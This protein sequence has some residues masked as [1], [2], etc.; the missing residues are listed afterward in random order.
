MAQL[1]RMPATQGRPVPRPPAGFS[2]LPA[3]MLPHW[4][5]LAEQNA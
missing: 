3:G 1:M 2:L 4:H 5:Q